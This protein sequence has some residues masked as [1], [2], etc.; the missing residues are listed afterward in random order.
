MTIIESLCNYFAEAPCL[1]QDERIGINFLGTGG[2][3]YAVF[4]LPGQETVKQYVDGTRIVAQLFTFA[5]VQ[6]YGAD[7]IASLE[8]NGFF[9]DLSDWIYTQNKKRKLP[10]LPDG[11]VATKIEAV[12]PGYAYDEDASRAKYQIQCRLEYMI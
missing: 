7:I 9:E 11:K 10:K 3:E 2:I 4:L 8:S 1:E 12:S 5:S 6:Y